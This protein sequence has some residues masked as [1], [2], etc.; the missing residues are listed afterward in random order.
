MPETLGKEW[1]DKMEGQWKAQ[2]K[3]AATGAFANH[4]D[5]KY[6]CTLGEVVATRSKAGDPQ[7][8]WTWII[9]AGDLEGEQQ[10]DFD[11]L[12]RDN[13]F[14]WLG[15]KLQK[16]GFDPDQLAEEGPRA[17]LEAIK[18]LNEMKPRVQLEL[19]T[20]KVG[21]KSYQNTNI[22]KVYDDSTVED[23]SADEPFNDKAQTAGVKPT[24]QIEEETPTPEVE[25]ALDSVPRIGRRAKFTVKGVEVEGVIEEVDKDDELANIRVG[26]KVRQIPFA[27]LELIPEAA[28]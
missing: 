7:I 4:P 6:D 16:F 3:K 1:L 21:D 12:T 15:L 2:M 11:G 26:N 8:N 27:D 23:E 5:A 22:V 28:L 20:K 10:M 13:A 14:F 25:A 18:L 19:K 24:R 17:L 9:E